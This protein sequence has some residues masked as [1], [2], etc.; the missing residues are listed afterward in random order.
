MDTR[1]WPESESFNDEGMHDKLP[2]KWYGNCES[3]IKCNKKLI[4]AQFFNKG[5]LAQKSKLATIVN[6]TRDTGGH[7]THTSSTVVGRKVDNA[8]LFGNANGSVKGVASRARLAIYKVM[9]GDA[10]Y[11]SDVIAAVDTAIS[12][13]V[14]IL[15]FSFGFNSFSLFDDPI[16]ITTF[17]AMDRGIF[18]STSAGNSGPS[19]ESLHNGIPWVIN[20]AA[21]TLD[22]QIQASLTLGNNVKLFGLSTYLIGKFST[23][24]VPIVFLGSCDNLTELVNAHN[25]IVVCEVMGANLR[26]L[27][28]NIKTTNVSASVL[29]SGVTDISIINDPSLVGIIIN[30]RNGEILT[31]YIKSNFDAKENMSFTITSLGI[32]PAPRV[33]VY[34]S[35]GLS[36]SCPFVLKP[37]ITA[38]GT[39][40]LAAWPQNLP[41][42]Y[43]GSRPLYSNFNL[44]TG[45][46]MACPHV[47]GVAA[48]LKGTHPDWSPATIRSAIMTTS[49]ILDNNKEP[50]K[51]IAMGGKPASPLAMGAGHINPN[52]A[53]EPGLV[54][55]VG[56][57]DYVNLLCTMNLTKQEITTIT[58]PSS[59]NC[60]KPSLDLNY[61]SFIALFSKS[62][63]FNESIGTWEFFRTVIN[64]GDGQTIYTASITPIKG[65]NV[66]LIPSK[67]VFKEKN[68]KVSFNLRIEGP[69]MEGF[70]YVTW[71][72]RKHVV[73]SPIVVTYQSSPY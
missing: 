44:L 63:S 2:T 34:S 36:I 73:R 41:V 32:K 66:S 69:K 52:K 53:L 67:L 24:Q 1:V 13:G 5:L 56:V 62:G 47:A 37:D 31:S 9:L 15:S 39:S 57:H 72:N 21:S 4:G 61:P 28:S 8:S 17:E 64:V 58:R 27:V 70:G 23:H 59:F 38:P 60:S 48:L 65:F 29:V 26:S 50:I 45:T 42:A 33:D 40:I 6:S 14:D 51:D 55:D 12:D 35:R 18:V 19:R 20:V 22:R 3:S 68:E 54:Y 49:D 10:I 30:P 43:S 11:P 7:G 46:S 71:T 16:A 25:K